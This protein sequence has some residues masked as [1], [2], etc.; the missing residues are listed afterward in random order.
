MLTSHQVFPSRRSGRPIGPGIEVR[1]D[2][3]ERRRRD[4]EELDA[5]TAL[6]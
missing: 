6:E 4:G 3:I 1:E 2:P 5:Y